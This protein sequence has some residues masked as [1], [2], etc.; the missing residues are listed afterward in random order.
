[1]SI[2]EQG[3]IDT[4][5]AET[6]R[7]LE[8]ASR[9]VDSEWDSIHRLA[10]DHRYGKESYKLSHD[11]A[12]SAARER[13]TAHPDMV[14]RMLARLDGFQQEVK[15]LRTTADGLEATY[16]ANPWSRFYIVAGGHIHSSMY[17]STCNKMGQLTRFGWL[18]EMSGQTEEAV[19][20]EY[21]AL[22]CTVCFPSAPVHWTNALEEAAKARKSAQCPGSGTYLNRDLPHRV[23][24]YSGNWATCPDC[25]ARPALTST[26]KLRAHKPVKN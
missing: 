21:G 23:G 9:R 3:I 24:Y 17:C 11:D 1:M 7:N 8:M 5:L 12:V 25:D 15:A 2:T 10:G 22:L 13:V 20:A 19:V 6:Y 14:D 4:E 16:A 26:G 18:P